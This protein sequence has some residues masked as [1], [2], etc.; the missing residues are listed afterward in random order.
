MLDITKINPNE[1]YR[2][3]TLME[4]EWITGPGNPTIESVSQA[5]VPPNKMI[6]GQRAYQQAIENNLFPYVLNM[7]QRGGIQHLAGGGVF[8]PIPLMEFLQYISHSPNGLEALKITLGTSA[9]G[10]GAYVSKD[11]FK[12]ARSKFSDFM[13]KRR[14]PDIRCGEFGGITTS[15][16]PCRNP[17]PAPGQRC[18]LHMNQNILNMKQRGGIQGFAEGLTS[19]TGLPERYLG[20]EFDDWEQVG[21]P[22]G[23]HFLQD[24]GNDTGA[25]VG[26]RNGVESGYG[27][28]GWYIET[29]MAHGVPQTA[30]VELLVEA[31]KK[32]QE[33]G[34][35]FSI[36][37]IKEGGSYSMHSAPMLLALEKMGLISFTEEERLLLLSKDPKKRGSIEING[38]SKTTAKTYIANMIDNFK[39]AYGNDYAEPFDENPGTVE[40]TKGLTDWKKEFLK[41][42]KIPLFEQM[43]GSIPGFQTGGGIQHLAG[44]GA[45]NPVLLVELLKIISLNPNKLEALKI[46]SGIGGAGFGA[47]LTKDLF[48]AA[49]SKFS[50]FMYKRKNPDIRCGEF[51]GITNSGMP[52]L[53]PVSAPGQRCYLHKS[54]SGISGF[55]SGGTPWVPGSGEGDR[56]PAML[57]PGEFVVNKN[58]AKQYGGLLNHLNWEAAP[59]FQLGSGN[60]YL[61]P[62]TGNSSFERMINRVTPFP[63]TEMK[64]FSQTLRDA[65][66][67]LLSLKSV[68]REVINGIKTGFQNP[69]YKGQLPSH[70]NASTSGGYKIGALARPAYDRLGIF[71]QGVSQGFENSKEG[72][73][74][75]RMEKVPTG[76]LLPNGEPEM[77]KPSMKMAKGFS[78]KASYLFGRQARPGMGTMMGGQMAGMLGMQMAGGMQDGYAKSAL[79]A[80]SMGTMLG[81]MT[82]LGP[83]GGAA[84]GAIA[85]G[86]MKAYS[87]WKEKLKN[88]A[89]LLTDSITMD[90]V[91]M[92]HLGVTA[93]DFSNIVYNASGKIVKASSEFQQGVN[94]Y[95]TSQDPLIVSALKGLSDLAQGGK[96]TKIEELMRSRFG[97]QFLATGGSPEARKKM[98]TEM[99]QFM[100]AGGVGSLTRKKIIEDYKTIKTPEQALTGILNNLPSINPLYPY[101]PDGPKNPIPLSPELQ[102][103]QFADPEVAK[104]AA[105]ATW[106]MQTTS[107]P[108]QLGKSFD[109]ATGSTKDMIEALNNSKEAWNSFEGIV[110]KNDSAMADLDRDFKK[111]G[112]TL[113]QVTRLNSLYQSG[114]TA[115]TTAQQKE[116]KAQPQLISGLE[117]ETSARQ[118]ADNAMSGYIANAEAHDAQMATQNSSLEK[119]TKA[120]KAEQDKLND[121]ID[122]GNKY[123][124]TE[125][126]KINKIQ[127]EKSAYDSLIQAQEQNI[128]NENT[129][130]NLKS[131]ITRARA[132]GDLLAMADAQSNYNAELQKQA[133]EKEKQARDN[134]YD[135]MMEKHQNNIQGAQKK[136][137]EYESKLKDLGKALDTLSQNASDKWNIIASAATPATDAANA[138]KDAIYSTA[139]QGKWNDFKDL[140]KQ[141]L[142]ADGVKGYLDTANINFGQLT[143]AVKEFA[144]SAAGKEMQDA[145]DKFGEIGNLISGIT[146][147]TKAA[148]VQQMAYAVVVSQ[149][150]SGK[151]TN[152]RQLHTAESKAVSLAEEFYGATPLKGGPEEGSRGNWNGKNVIFHNYLWHS[153]ENNKGKI[154]YKD[155]AVQPKKGDNV[156][157]VKPGVTGPQTKYNLADGGYISG[158]GNGTSDSIPARLSNGEYVVK[159]SA[160]SQYGTGFLD[161]VNGQRFK[162]GGAVKTGGFATWGTTPPP[163]INHSI[164]AQN[165]GASRSPSRVQTPPQKDKKQYGSS[166]SAVFDSSDRGRK[167]F[168]GSGILHDVVNP[169]V[170]I[171]RGVGYQTER[172]LRNA[173][174]G[175]ANFGINAAAGIAGRSANYHMEASKN[176]LF[177]NNP[178]KTKNDKNGFNVKNFA[179]DVA[180]AGLNF[181]PIKLG[182]YLTKIPV[183]GPM[184]GKA[185]T[186][187]KD[188][189]KKG[190]SWAGKELHSAGKG[191][192]EKSKWYL[193]GKKLYHGSPGDIALGDTLRSRK[194]FGPSTTTRPDIA[195]QYAEGR[196]MFGEKG[197]VYIVKTAGNLSGSQGKTK[198]FSKDWLSNPTR[199]VNSDQPFTVIKEYVP[200]SEKLKSLGLPQLKN[201]TKDTFATLLSRFSSKKLIKGIEDL[202]KDAL[203]IGPANKKLDLKSKILHLYTLLQSSI[204]KKSAAKRLNFDVIKDLEKMLKDPIKSNPNIIGGV[205]IKSGMLGIEDLLKKTSTPEGLDLFKVISERLSRHDDNLRR[206]DPTRKNGGFPDWYNG[207]A[208]P[209]RGDL[210]HFLSLSNFGQF[211]QIGKEIFQALKMKGIRSNIRE[212]FLKGKYNL[213]DLLF[214][215]PKYE[216]IPYTTREVNPRDPGDYSISLHE[217]VQE[218]KKDSKFKNLFSH[219]YTEDGAPTPITKLFRGRGLSKELDNFERKDFYD[220]NRWRKWHGKDW[221]SDVN[222][223]NKKAELFEEEKLKEMP[224]GRGYV[225]LET[226]ARYFADDLLT[227]YDYATYMKERLSTFKIY[228]KITTGKPK[229]F[230]SGLKAGIQK[231]LRFDPLAKPK[232]RMTSQQEYEE[233]LKTKIEINDYRLLEDKIQKGRAGEFLKN[234][235]VERNKKDIEKDPT[236]LVKRY[237]MMNSRSVEGFFSPTLWGTWDNTATRMSYYG[238]NLLTPRDIP[239]YLKE[240]WKFFATGLFKKADGGKISG[241]GGPKSDMIPA[242]LSNGEYVINAEAVSRYGTGFMDMVNAKKFGSGGPVMNDYMKSDIVHHQP[243]DGWRWDKKKK[244]YVL[245]TVVPKSIAA[246][247]SIKPKNLTRMFDTSAMN[248]SIRVSGQTGAGTFNST[249]NDHTVYNIT[250]NA[251]TGANPQD[252]AKMV[253][254]EIQKTNKSMGTSRRQGA[255][256]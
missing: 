163:S 143:G 208:N 233:F 166:W 51:G 71:G 164:W 244:M 4:R 32:L 177:K 131:A 106:S 111:A 180:L 17:A 35:D 168:W 56:I 235:L 15:G 3:T 10:F 223:I 72:F 194:R 70:F 197:K 24:H 45:I 55:Q 186:A 254:G 34:Q 89:D 150:A 178:Y 192:F 220:I 110:R 251:K 98:Y 133:D 99:Q 66:T 181:V 162:D 256:I 196:G 175:V 183:V 240:K 171:G 174:A 114:M 16:M 249:I 113:E 188:I 9:A 127:K 48:K 12:A 107:D 85:G 232:L 184:L 138:V 225:D 57:E 204:L 139:M 7:K 40:R 67:S 54:Q 207:V 172:G 83:I 87:N 63:T 147:K 253:M 215:R 1:K 129:L 118:A 245:P 206:F 144:D 33:Y 14:N 229:N 43:G 160:V 157:I 64:T 38:L 120:N 96:T 202:Q 95:K 11:L 128:Q 20:T 13:Y 36:S 108:L 156:W 173:A 130:N 42:R 132:G 49:R 18:Y 231:S 61:S 134:R 75:G 73:Q 30:I 199:E 100:S 161:A 22:I 116:I 148:Q 47:Y 88:Q 93:R 187:L 234:W 152:K 37:A 52:C 102:K 124:D 25:Y 218:I 153:Y 86:A 23:L 145:T 136:I 92:Q 200:L 122:A 209:A 154:V 236:L 159:A 77:A 74:L 182:K 26:I 31:R 21:D 237:K 169:F 155:L 78:G 146:D 210:N 185:G 142:G 119:K 62:P 203:G 205:D 41:Q 28:P 69:S 80:A 191:L 158:A 224:N 81:S 90:S 213:L 179:G 65:R 190:L 211:K 117:L 115:L 91:A 248:K 84:V 44:G 243:I 239:T 27:V 193:G 165:K 230:F 189:S 219:L 252:I 126:N 79:N 8:N 94:D 123:I 50:D 76:N 238:D 103:Q 39:S 149:I 19:K 217:Y 125:Q 59:R 228:S 82:P 255:R 112:F 212:T 216:E 104:Q 246:I 226:G 60:A 247:N 141:V 68:P 227:P 97:G 222:L 170:Q 29:A 121:L 176:S 137:G 140:A 167:G 198:L 250:V 214:K 241:P 53:N 151:I 201:L 242:M 46:A 101:G 2:G 58:A 109:R 105:K 221:M 5:W 195:K 6:G 135:Q